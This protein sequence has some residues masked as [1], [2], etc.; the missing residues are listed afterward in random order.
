M[1]MNK[2]RLTRISGQILARYGLA[3][4]ALL[5]ALLMGRALHPFTAEYA[6]YVILLLAVVFAGWYC[7]VGPSILTLVFA[8]VAARYWFISPLHSLRIPNTAEGI[9]LVVF[10]FASGAVVALGEARRRDNEKLHQAQR[11]LE[12][13]VQERTAELDTANRSLRELSARLLQSQDDERRRIARE[14]HDSVGQMLAALTMNLSAVRADIERVAR[15]ATTLTDSEGLVQQMSTEVRTISHLLHPPLLDE[16]GLS[17]AVRWYLDGFAQRSNIKVDLDLPADFGRLSRELETAIFRV[18]QEC[19]TNIHRHSGSS[20]AKVRLRQRDGEVL[21]EVGDRG[22]GV[23][24]EKRDELASGGT[25]GVGI[26]GMRE[27]LRQLGGS[28]EITSHGT[29]TIVLARFPV[30]EPPLTEEIRVVSD[31]SSTAAA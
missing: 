7:G 30:A 19:L 15:T 27:R 12:D 9:G 13:R 14:L 20:I 17:S 28:L 16:A 18:V 21:V 1:S 26:R 25:P 11:E 29:G 22:K 23:P 4:T 24:P 31:S 10:L 5:A 2:S 6:P 8:L 3:V